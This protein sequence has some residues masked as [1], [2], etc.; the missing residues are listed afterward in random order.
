MP[1]PP[2]VAALEPA[3]ALARPTGGGGVPVCGRTTWRTS[4][5]GEVGV[6]GAHARQRPSFVVGDR[7][8]SRDHPARDPAGRRQPG[9]RSGA[10]G[11][12]R[13]HV[14]GRR[15]RGR[16]RAAALH[17]PRDRLR[18]LRVAAFAHVAPELP[19]V[20]AAS[21]L[22]LGEVGRVRVEHARRRRPLRARG[23]SRRR[24]PD[25]PQ[26]KRRTRTAAPPAGRPTPGRPAV[27]RRS[28]GRDATGRRYAGHAAS[29]AVVR[30]RTVRPPRRRPPHR[31][32]ARR[33]VRDR[34]ADD[35]R[36]RTPPGVLLISRPHPP[37]V[38]RTHFPGGG[39]GCGS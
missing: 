5:R 15:V 28:C 36:C 8:G 12:D 37:N 23:K 7:V 29:A 32:R 19:S 16:R 18:R 3:L 9:R 17:P 38:R 25:A 11:L 4:G 22:P 13:A 24:H 39:P 30:T 20:A 26:R 35:H 33:P 27:A 6:A 10:V 31:T 1:A 21:R 2:A 34:R 14:R